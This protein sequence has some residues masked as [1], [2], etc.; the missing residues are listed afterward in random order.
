MNN[1]NLWGSPVVNKANYF[2]FHDESIPNKR[3]LLIGLLFVRDSDK[4]VVVK[5]LKYWRQKENYWGEIHFSELPSSFGGEWGAKAR[6]ARSWLKAYENGLYEMAFFTALAVDKG[7]PAFEHKRFSNDYHIYN[8]FTAMALKA[9][10][11]W[12][13]GSQKFKEVHINFVSDAK[14]R[15]TRP[16]K[17]MIDNFEDYIPY[18]AV[19][20]SYLSKLGGKNYPNVIVD[21]KL[22]NS[23]SNDLLQLCDL[24]LGAT[25]AAL[26][27]NSKRKTK[28]ELGRKIVRWHEDTQKPPWDQEYKFHRKFS[29]WAFPNE[30]GQPYSNILFALKDDNQLMFPF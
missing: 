26:T 2:V 6:V 27:G 20:D 21:L 22:E 28:K 14:D 23:A 9:G 1:V 17:G 8:R 18:R 25:Q 15:S 16:D 3:W 19:L 7:S 12:F 30:N 13:L 10:I 24:M 4:D 5:I 11:S 29:I